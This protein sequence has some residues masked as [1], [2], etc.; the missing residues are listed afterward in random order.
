MRPLFKVTKFHYLN[1]SVDL[2]FIYVI[3]CTYSARGIQMTTATQ[4]DTIHKF[5]IAGLGKAPFKLIGFYKMPS[6]SLAGQNPD[7]YNMAL[8]AMP[9]GA[10]CGSCQFCGIP[11]INNFII[12][13]SDGQ[14]NAVGCDCVQKVGDRGLTTKIKEMQRIARK[15]KRDAERE[16]TRLAKLEA[17]REKNGGKTDSEIFEEKVNARNK[18]IEQGMVSI[19]ESLTAI[20]NALKQAYG[21]FARNM[22]YLIKEGDFSA[23]SPNM[24]RII[25]EIA[26]KQISGARKGSKKYLA[27]FD[28]LEPVM[29]NA[30]EEYKKLHEANPRP[31]LS[32]Y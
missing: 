22:Y 19:E 32:N 23:I 25:I 3:I 27:E 18:A 20:R 16:A 30:R 12:E 1:F 10:G 14:K 29:Q 9:Q 15:E 28:T 2:I 24:Q 6:N 21:D 13:S 26:A 17:E 8:R 31:T 5:E 4:N 7:A 11:L